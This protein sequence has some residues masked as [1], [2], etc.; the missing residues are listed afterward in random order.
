MTGVCHC[1]CYFRVKAGMFEYAGKKARLTLSF[2]G[3]RSTF[4]CRPSLQKFYF[5]PLS[6]VCNGLTYNLLVRP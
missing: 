6:G 5:R 1:Q 3:I 4:M 2:V